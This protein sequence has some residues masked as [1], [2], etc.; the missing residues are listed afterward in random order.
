MLESLQQLDQSLLLYLNGLHAPFWDNFMW[1][2]S[3]K[4]IWVPMYA[5]LLF[6]LC[7]NLN[8]KLTLFTVVAITLT[9]TFADQICA[10]VIRPIVGRMRPSN[11]N[12]PLSE[13]VHILHNKRGGSYGFPS[14]HAA[15]SFALAFFVLLF[16]KQRVLTAFL[17]I[18]AL[19]NSYS[20]IYLGVHYP[21]DLLAGM[22][23]GLCGALLIYYLYRWALKQPTIA[24]AFNYEGDRR[25]IEKPQ[26]LS[27]TWLTICV[28]LATISIIALVSVIQ[29]F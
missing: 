15:N 14:C 28:G 11:P 18:W 20:R 16:F 9:V 1:L 6:I 12:N 5:T 4:W 13:F 29:L 27:H 7:K 19:V 17:I 23:V 2:F 24:E 21:G 8:W 10:T 3:G 22:L 26:Q 25:L